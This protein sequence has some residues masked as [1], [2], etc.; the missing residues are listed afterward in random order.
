MR[1]PDLSRSDLT[2]SQSVCDKTRETTMPQR[3]LRVLSVAFLI[4]L[5]SA[6][7]PTASAAPATTLYAHA[8]PANCC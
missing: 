3:S 6:L 4:T 8:M 5:A 7:A 1:R 2:A